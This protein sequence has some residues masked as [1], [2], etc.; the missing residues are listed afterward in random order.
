KKQFLAQARGK[1]KFSDRPK[2]VE[3]VAKLG[4]IELFA[5]LDALKTCKSEWANSSQAVKSAFATLGT[6]I[7]QIHAD[8][9][10]RQEYF[11]GFAF[12]EVAELCGLDFQELVLELIKSFA[13]PDHDLPPSV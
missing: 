5:K 1:T 10:V 4:N 7:V 12:R 6:T 11:Y 13:A 2:H 9:F 8:D 3:A